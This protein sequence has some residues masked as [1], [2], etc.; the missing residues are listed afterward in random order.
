MPRGDDPFALLV[1][2][3]R[4]RLQTHAGMGSCTEGRWYGAPMLGMAT[5]RACGS[6]KFATSHIVSAVRSRGRC[7]RRRRLSALVIVHSARRAGIV[8]II[9]NAWRM[10]VLVATM[11]IVVVVSV[12]T[13]GPAHAATDADRVRAVLD[14]MNSSYNRSDF[15]A[16]ASHLCADILRVRGFEAGW[17]ESRETDGPTQIAV[18]SVDVTGDDAVANV[19]FEAANREDAKTLD[20]DFVREAAE[21]KACRYH[22]AQFV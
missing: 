12:A 1:L 19:R 16:F 2:K 15:D 14:M 20:V 7:S 13:A 22:S 21:W 6:T 4:W 17:H 18:N 9:G 10:D 8:A 3:L 11:T 5:D